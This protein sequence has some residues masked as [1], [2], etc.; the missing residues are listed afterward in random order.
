MALEGG[1]PREHPRQRLAEAEDSLDD[2][3][4]RGRPGDFPPVDNNTFSQ[5]AGT[6]TLSERRIDGFESSH[7]K[8]LESTG[9]S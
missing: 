2:G 9:A 3:T 5:G 8:F 1:G 6:P 7:R 4:E